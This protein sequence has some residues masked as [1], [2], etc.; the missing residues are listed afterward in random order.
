M[1]IVGG[2]EPEQY[3]RGYSAMPC[4]TAQKLAGCFQPRPFWLLVR[5]K[6]AVWAATARLQNELWHRATPIWPE[7]HQRT[8]RRPHDMYVAVQKLIGFVNETCS[9]RFH[10]AKAGWPRYLSCFDGS[11]AYPDTWCDFGCAV[12]VSCEGGVGVISRITCFILPSLCRQS[13]KQ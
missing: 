4:V 2:Q 8:R 11:A 7:R 9:P 13:E 6:Q 1:A 5:Q 10:W 3:A 12:Q